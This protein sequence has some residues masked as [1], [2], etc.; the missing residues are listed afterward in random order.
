MGIRSW[1]GKGRQEADDEALKNA[2][3][4]S[5]ESSAERAHEGNRM[6]QGADNAVSGRIGER[7]EDLNRLGDFNP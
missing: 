2:E 6:G 1:F 4:D 7:P 3:E 5:F